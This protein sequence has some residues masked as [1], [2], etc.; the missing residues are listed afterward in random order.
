MNT[1]RKTTR[2]VEE[3]L[4]NAGVPPLENQAPPQDNQVPPKHQ[5]PV[6][7]SP[8]KDV[9]ISSAFVTLSQ[10]MTTQDKAVST[11]AQAIRLKQI[12]RL[13]PVFDQMLV[14]C[15]PLEGLHEYEPSDVLWIESE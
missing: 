5:A 6:I 11:Q 8:M 10:A 7:P 1:R 12:G 13:D 4:N 15:F 9:E 14:P 3:N 2:R